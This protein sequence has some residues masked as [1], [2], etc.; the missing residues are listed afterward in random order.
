MNAWGLAVGPDVEDAT[1]FGQ[2]ETSS[3]G[4]FDELHPVESVLI[5]GPVAVGLPLGLGE[6][7]ASFVEPDRLGRHAGR[8]GEFA[9]VHEAHRTL[10]LEP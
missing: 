3:L 9:D 1:D 5:V 4:S 8:G 6:Q 10:D 7:S 2:G